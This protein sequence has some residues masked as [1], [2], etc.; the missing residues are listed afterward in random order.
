MTA[1]F[2][3]RHAFVFKLPRDEAKP[4]VIWSGVGGP[5]KD[6][7]AFVD[8]LRNGKLDDRVNYAH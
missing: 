1:C 4:K 2:D 5:L 7:A 3:P 6:Y 8:A